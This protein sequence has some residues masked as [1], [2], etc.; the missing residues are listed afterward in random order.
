[1]KRGGIPLVACC[2]S[3]IKQAGVSD[4]FVLVHVMAS[5]KEAMKP[6]VADQMH[7]FGSIRRE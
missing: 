7:L 3:T 6:V 4:I 5:T 1:L 2:I